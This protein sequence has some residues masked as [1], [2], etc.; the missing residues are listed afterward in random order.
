MTGGFFFFFLYPVRVLRVFGLFQFHFGTTEH[1][2]LRGTIYVFMLQLAYRRVNRTVFYTD[3]TNVM[4]IVRRARRQRYQRWRFADGGTALMLRGRGGDGFG[5]G[6]IAG[7]VGT[8]RISTFARITH[9]HT[10]TYC[11]M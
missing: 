11:I 6:R 8:V 9:T 4:S 7:V 1:T 3:T 10:H 2:G 5:D